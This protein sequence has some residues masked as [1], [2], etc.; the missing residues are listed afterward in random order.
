MKLIATHPTDGAL[1]K[2][3]QGRTFHVAPDGTQTEIHIIE[4]GNAPFSFFRGA[5]YEAVDDD[6]AQDDDAQEEQE[7]DDP[8]GMNE[9][10]NGIKDKGFDAALIL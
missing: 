6:D 9:F 2:D 3:E 4:D 8:D 1:Y 7:D 5:F 10:L